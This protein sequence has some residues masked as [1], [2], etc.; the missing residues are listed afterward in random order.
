MLEPYN[1]MK[2]DKDIVTGYIKDNEIII[3]MR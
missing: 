3:N 1:H 2:K